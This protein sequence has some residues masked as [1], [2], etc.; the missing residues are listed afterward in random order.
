MPRLIDDAKWKERWIRSAAASKTGQTLALFVVLTITP[1]LVP[2]LHRYRVFLPAAINPAPADGGTEDRSQFPRP[3]A[4]AVTGQVP[5]PAT[6]ANAAQGAGQITSMPGEIEDPSGHALDHFFDALGKAESGQAVARVSHYGDS[7][8]TNDGIT[9]TI[10]RQLQRR[11]GDAG[12]GFI[13]ID[14]PWGWYEHAGI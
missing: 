4:E 10:R 1:Y 3:A 2:G 7:P 5:G 8:I 11:F 13:L 12:H 9:S 6:A 14:K